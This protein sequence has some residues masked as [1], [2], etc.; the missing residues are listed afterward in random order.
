[1]SDE[2][3]KE[4]HYFESPKGPCP[5]LG[6]GRDGVRYWDP[7]EPWGIDS[8]ELRSVKVDNGSKNKSTW[9]T[10]WYDKSGD[11]RCG[12][13]VK[14]GSGNT[15]R[16]K[17]NKGRRCGNTRLYANGR[18][19]RHG[20]GVYSGS[21]KHG[22]YMQLRGP[23]KDAKERAEADRALLDLRPL[24][25]LFDLRVEELSNRVDAGSAGAEEWS[26]AKTHWKA[27]LK[28][29]KHDDKGAMDYH[30]KELSILFD[31]ATRSER[32]WKEMLSVAKERLARTEKAQA[33]MISSANM[34]AAHDVRW[35]IARLVDV[36]EEESNGTAASRILERFS[37]EVLGRISPSE[38]EAHPAAVESETLPGV[39]RE[40][41]SVRKGDPGR[42]VL[43]SSEGDL[44]GAVPASEGSGENVPRNRE[45]ESGSGDRGDVPLHEGELD[46]GVDGSV[47]S[48]SEGPSVGGD[49]GD[50]RPRKRPRKRST[51]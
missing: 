45:D 26:A 37:T 4:R 49:R 19:R 25:A 12:A 48:P 23:L 40:G 51:G 3:P 17:Q 14:G 24:L 7:D 18:C 31:T 44:R 36:V 47:G 2:K 43:E 28:A 32:T 16:Y 8:S 34:L 5:P 20:G 27:Y 21:A 38:A 9:W 22:K 1:M 33:L 35:A 13:L 10:H 6:Y 42:E 46:R 50:V 29:Q 39:P 11:Q 30:K 41:A 15:R